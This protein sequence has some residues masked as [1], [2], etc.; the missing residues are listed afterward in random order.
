MKDDKNLQE[1][2]KSDNLLDFGSEGMK[3]TASS[4][5]KILIIIFSLAVFLFAGTTRIKIL[6]ISHQITGEVYFETRVVE[7]DI[8]EYSWIHSFEHIPWNEEYKVKNNNQLMLTSISV[9]GFGAGI[10]ENKGEVSVENGIIYMRNI[11]QIFNE[12][13]WINSNTALS[14]IRLNG[15]VLIEGSSMPHHEPCILQ[16]KEKYILWPFR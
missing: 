3:C 15:S 4:R 6:T 2:S 5:I 11:N 14:N 9:A 16:V 12:I 8:I 1:K 10:P 13:N 7:G